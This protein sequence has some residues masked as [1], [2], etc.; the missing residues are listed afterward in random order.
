MASQLQKKKAAQDLAMY[1]AEKGYIVAGREYN[2]DPDRPAHLKISKVKK[3][4][5]NWSA[6][7]STVRSFEPELME[8]LTDTKPEPKPEPVEHPAVKSA[9]PAEKAEDEGNDAEDI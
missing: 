8:G 5:R 4:F 1:F 6:M 3:L 2:Q 7:L 9:K